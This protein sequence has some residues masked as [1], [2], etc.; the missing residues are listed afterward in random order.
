MGNTNSQNHTAK[1][2]IGDILLEYKMIS[3]NLFKTSDSIPK[4]EYESTATAQQQAQMLDRQQALLV[5]AGSM[6]IEN[7][8]D[9]FAL[10]ELW[11]AD[12]IYSKEVTP[13][14]GIVLHLQD[15]LKSKSA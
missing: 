10:L 11:K 9:V 15:Y 7:G 2:S 14:Q 13:S 5:E 8:N 4:D 1:R 6:K 12:E 3:I